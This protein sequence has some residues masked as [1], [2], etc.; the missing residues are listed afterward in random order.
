MTA[1]YVRKKE[2]GSSLRRKLS[3]MSSKYMN[4]LERGIHEGGLKIWLILID[5]IGEQPTLLPSGLP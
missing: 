3:I 1:S 4:E 2:S 5:K